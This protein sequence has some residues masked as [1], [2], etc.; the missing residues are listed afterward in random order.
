MVVTAAHCTTTPT[1]ITLGRYD[2]DDPD[3]YDY[4][5]MGV[6]EKI[7]HP[8]YDKAVVENDLA[9]LVLERNSVHPWV[10]VNADGLVPYQGEELAV[11]VSRRALV[12]GNREITCKLF[13]SKLQRATVWDLQ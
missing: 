5:I 13:S 7:V 3:D 1:K 2:L 12:L 10:R 8:D 4:E 6:I 11:M 9:L